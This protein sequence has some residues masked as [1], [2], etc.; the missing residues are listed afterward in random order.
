MLQHPICH[1]AD[2]MMADKQK[3]ETKGNIEKQKKEIMYNIKY[4]CLQLTNVAFN[5]LLIFFD[6]IFGLI[7][8]KENYI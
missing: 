1:V 2:I 5:S 4:K 6:F 7:K 8:E 3:K